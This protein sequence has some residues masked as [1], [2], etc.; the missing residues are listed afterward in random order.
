MQEYKDLNHMVK[1]DDS[2]T[3]DNIN[4]PNGCY[5]PHHAVLKEDSLTPKLRVV[6]DASCKSSIGVSINDAMMVGPVIQP[7]LLNI[8]MKFR[9]HLFVFTANMSKMYRQIRVHESDR[10]Y[11]QIVWCEDS[12]HPLDTYELLKLTCGTPAAFHLATQC[13]Q[14]LGNSVSDSFPTASIAIVQGLHVD[15][16]L[17]SCDSIS[18][19]K[20]LRDQLIEILG[21]GCFKW[22]KWNANKQEILESDCIKQVIV[23][24]SLTRPINL[25][26]SEFVGSHTRILFHIALIRLVSTSH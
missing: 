1:I 13:V 24:L 23:P 2:Y 25:K 9:I 12:D 17:T 22:V 5:L 26:F 10:K 15:D 16:I 3:N 4:A 19:A 8:L 7:D 6:F 21:M 11:Q 18:D 20:K 14:F